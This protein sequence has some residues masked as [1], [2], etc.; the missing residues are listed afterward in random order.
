MAVQTGNI[1]FVL[2]TLLPSFSH[3]L[4]SLGSFVGLDHEI[5]LFVGTVLVLPN[6][7]LVTEFVHFARIDRSVLLSTWE[8]DHP[9]GF[10]GEGGNTFV[11]GCQV[12]GKKYLKSR[13]KTKG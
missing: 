6:G 13:K 1:V 7:T 3:T 11:K 10:E 4:S 9:Q 2:V 5:T 8:T 12:L